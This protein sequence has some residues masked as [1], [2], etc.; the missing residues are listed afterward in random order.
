[1]S[2]YRSL[3]RE[4][5][6][7]AGAPIWQVSS[8]S[9]NIAVGDNGNGDEKKLPNKHGSCW[10]VWIAS[11]DGRVY[12]YRAMEKD[13]VGVGSDLDASALQIELALQCLG[14]SQPAVPVVGSGSDGDSVAVTALG[15][16][17]VNDKKQHYLK[18]AIYCYT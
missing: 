9:G 4:Q 16:S 6:G 5:V 10:H 17:Q 2:G 8:S 3:H 11:G 7:S 14:P 12:A 18:N 13:G 1:M 15:C